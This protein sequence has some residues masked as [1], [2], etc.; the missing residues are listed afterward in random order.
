MYKMAE[1]VF[2]STAVD[3]CSTYQIDRHNEEIIKGMIHYFSRSLE[4]INGFDKNKG[5]SLFGGFGTGKTMLLKIFRR[6]INGTDQG[7]K[8]QFAD[9]GEIARNFIRDGVTSLEQF[10]KTSVYETR[11]E[12]IFDDLGTEVLAQHYGNKFEVMEHVIDIAYKNFSS[13]GNRYYFTTNLPEK[14][15]IERY[16]V[17]QWDRI[18]EM[19][20]FVILSGDSRRK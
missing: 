15:L 4:P 12:W 9:C 2:T 20:N 16:G 19:T 13:G 6:I 1:S 11:Q 8:I 18:I 5:L 10:E 14:V 3:L 7:R 17:R